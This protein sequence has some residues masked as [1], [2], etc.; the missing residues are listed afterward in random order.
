[1]KK[2][3]RRSYHYAK[4]FHIAK[5]LR[6][7]QSGPEFF[8]VLCLLIRQSKRKI[9]LH[10]YILDEDETGINVKNELIG[11]ALNGVEIS[12]LLDGYGSSKLSEKFILDLQEA[13]IKCRFFSKISLWYNL[14]LGRRLHH[15]IV[16]VDDEYALVGGINIANRYSGIDQDMA[17]LDYAIYIHSINCYE[18]T[19]VCL[20]LEEQRFIKIRKRRS[21]LF[22]PEGPELKISFRQNDWLRKKVQIYY[23]YIQAIRKA[24]QHIT[25]FGSYFLPGRKLRTELEKARKRGVDIRIVMAGKS[26]LPILLNASYY[27]YN[28]MHR[29]GIKI[30]EWNASV[31]HAKM[32]F[33]DDVWMTVGSFN[34]NRLST[35]GSIELNVDIHST[36]FVK[37]TRQQLEDIIQQCMEIEAFAK[38]GIFLQVRDWLAYVLGRMTIQLVTY[39]SKAY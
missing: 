29:F 10:S 9:H 21:P 4:T 34:L 22:N 27:L 37:K 16:V 7:L 15:K 20:A 12:L 8:E 30:Y 6:L 35:Y 5:D 11:A 13:G 18:L 33:V 2:F 39:F 3:F 17:W 28:W 36:E 1:M 38:R 32:A 14:N 24:E 23:S 31:L 25:I 19:N 26:D